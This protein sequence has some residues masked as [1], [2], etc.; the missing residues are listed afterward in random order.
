MADYYMQYHNATKLKHY[1]DN[2][3]NIKTDIETISLDTTIRPNNWI[4]VSKRINILN[5]KG[6]I[7]FL[8]V[9]KKEKGKTNFYLW[10]FFRIENFEEKDATRNNI[11]GTGCNFPKP[12]LL[13]N[14]ENFSKFQESCANFVRFRNITML[15]FTQNLCSFSSKITILEVLTDEAEVFLEEEQ[16]IL[17]QINQLKKKLIEITL[18]NDRPIVNRLKEIA[19]YKCQF[20]NCTAEILMEDGNKYVEVAHIIAVKDGGKSVHG[21]LIVLCPNHHKEFDYGNLTMT[22]T[23]SKLTGQLNGKIF[24]IE[25]ANHDM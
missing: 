3:F 24:E 21:N 4:H 19:N 14:I 6:S 1:P 2:V 10:S 20:P 15:P 11:S 17:N 23:S 25:L 8:I 5:A 12:I 16:K 7:C 9:G 13:N 22:C 18:R